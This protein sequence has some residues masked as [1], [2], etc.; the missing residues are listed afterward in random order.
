M[1]KL[2]IIKKIGGWG[3]RGERGM[4]TPSLVN[5]QRSGRRGEGEMGPAGLKFGFIHI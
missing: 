4:I 2:N 5:S 1:I 3:K